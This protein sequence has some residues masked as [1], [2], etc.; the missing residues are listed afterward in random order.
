[1]GDFNFR[2]QRGEEETAG[3]TEGATHDIGE[4]KEECPRS[5]VKFLKNRIMIPVKR[6]ERSGKLRICRLTTR[7]CDMVV[8]SD[9]GSKSFHWTDEG[10]SL[11]GRG[12]KKDG[13]RG[14]RDS[15]SK[16][17]LE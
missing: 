14:S 17:L 10:E 5:Q 3:K 1:M 15:N 6:A 4:L 8:S 9:F 2:S 11:M 16:L 13:R 12:S 7:C